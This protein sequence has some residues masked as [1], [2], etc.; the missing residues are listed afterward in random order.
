M[1]KNKIYSKIHPDKKYLPDYGPRVQDRWIIQRLSICGKSPNDLA[2]SVGKPPNHL[3]VY[4]SHVINIQNK[5]SQIQ[6]A[7]WF[8]GSGLGE[9]LKKKNFLIYLCIFL[10]KI[11][12]NRQ[13]V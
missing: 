5:K 12:S 6:T 8:D 7:K 4:L 9:F 1:S 2:V 10:K 3:A 13:M 11:K